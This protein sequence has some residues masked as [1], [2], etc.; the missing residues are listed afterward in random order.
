MMN[1][2]MF[3]N[4]NEICSDTEN[5]SNQY[6]TSTADIIIHNFINYERNTLEFKTAPVNYKLCYNI[7]NS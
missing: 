6:I 2:S 3:Q 5:V 4:E 1:L 7:L